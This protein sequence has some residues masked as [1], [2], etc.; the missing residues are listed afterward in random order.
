M[1][2]KGSMRLPLLSRIL[3][4]RN[5][6]QLGEGQGMKPRAKGEI[7]LNVKRMW[8]RSYYIST[9]WDTTRCRKRS[10]H[11]YNKSSWI[12]LVLRKIKRNGAT[13]SSARFNKRNTI[14]TIKY[15]SPLR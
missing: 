6:S 3:V 8:E 11:N 14:C 4:I 1:G 9:W 2:R 15:E 12:A 10:K 13:I 5:K 7:Q